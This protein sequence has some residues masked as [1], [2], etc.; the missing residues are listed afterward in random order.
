MF[1][2]NSVNSEYFKIDDTSDAPTKSVGV[3][4][5][6]LSPFERFAN[7]DVKRFAQLNY[8]FFARVSF[9]GPLAIDNE[10][11][12][13]FCISIVRQNCKS[14]TLIEKVTYVVQ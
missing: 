11:I 5:E 14:K 2:S 4:C 12:F 3:R 9:E 10:H 8:H 6:A 1:S 7:C 13:N